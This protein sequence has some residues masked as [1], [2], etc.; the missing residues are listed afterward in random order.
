MKKKEMKKNELKEEFEANKIR[1]W[2]KYK[3]EK[4]IDIKKINLQVEI[5][6]K[7]FEEERQ[8]DFF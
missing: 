2:K 5:E 6:K 1:K 4:K 7:K 3:K 8:R